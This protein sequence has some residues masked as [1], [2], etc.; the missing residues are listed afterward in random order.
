MREKVGE[1]IYLPAP[2]M[3]CI[4]GRTG[5]LKDVDHELGFGL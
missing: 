1:K 2:E 5:M 3:G 4:A